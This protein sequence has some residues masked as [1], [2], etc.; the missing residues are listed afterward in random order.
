M[1]APAL[2]L[3]V[4]ISSYNTRVLLRNCLQ[5]IYRY[6]QGISFEIICVDDNSSDGSA[7]MVSEIFPQV[8]LFRNQVNAAL[9]QESESR[10]GRVARALCLSAGQ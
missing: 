6:T 2:D 3:T 8:I 1:I 10:H 5:S 4:I 9:C 7:D